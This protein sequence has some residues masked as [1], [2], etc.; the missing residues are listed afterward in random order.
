MARQTIDRGW[1]YWGHGQH[2]RDRPRVLLECSAD[3]SPVAAAHA[4]VDAGCDVTVCSGPD[5]RH[6]CSLLEY[7]RCPLLEEA[8]VVVNCLDPGPL[9]DDIIAAVRAVRPALPLVVP[10]AGEEPASTLD[11]LCRAPITFTSP[12]R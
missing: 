2:E 5:D 8:D 9:N 6:N 3:L 4:L 12:A 7:G 11:V 1:L 10:S